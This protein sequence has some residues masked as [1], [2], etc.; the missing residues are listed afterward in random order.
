MKKN[1]IHAFWYIIRGMINETYEYKNKIFK[2]SYAFKI[3]VTNKFI[4]IYIYSFIKC[5]HLI[6]SACIFFIC[7]M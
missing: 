4:Y 1:V 3:L 5:S 7:L 6:E 2:S